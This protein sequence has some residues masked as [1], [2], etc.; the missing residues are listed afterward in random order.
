MVDQR[1]LALYATT[2]VLMMT[3]GLLSPFLPILAEDKGVTK[4]EVGVMFS[5]Y[6][7]GSLVISP[8]LGVLMYKFGRRN[9]L[10]VAYLASAGAF[11]IA[12]ISVYLDSLSFTVLNVR[13]RFLNGVAIGTM[14]TVD[15]AVIA[16]DYPDQV[17]KYLGM[18]ESFVG[19]SFILGPIVGAGLYIALGAAGTFFA[20][21]AF[22][23]LFGT[24]IYWI[25]GPDRAY[26]IA[27]KEQ[28]FFALAI[29]PRIIIALSPLLYY[30]FASGGVLVFFPTHLKDYGLSDA[31]VVASYTLTGVGYLL[32]CVILAH[33]IENMNK[34]IVNSVGLLLGVIAVALIGPFPSFLPQEV[35]TILIG[36]SL[37]PMS[38]G[39]LFVII[40]P[41]LIEVATTH[42]GLVN[43]DKLLD[44][45][46][47]TLYSAIEVLVLAIGE[48]SG[49]LVTGWGL[50]HV[51]VMQ[52]CGLLAGGGLVIMVIYIATF[53]SCKG[54]KRIPLIPADRNT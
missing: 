20:I 7:A 47:G 12:G 43:D 48:L 23:L 37:Y 28:N 16:S 22:F 8:I 42:L 24:V 30:V 17:V 6:P 44:K 49:P 32:I 4:G 41:S 19:L 51:G 38:S 5:V 53:V 52:W 35:A 29:Q 45:L 18:N 9:M 1:L 36:W 2:T 14:F 54:T 21:S 13:S 25:L 40:M 3:Y 39:A 33:T 10:Y 50:P 15:N 11:L 26:R 34:T 46:S 27:N 31:W